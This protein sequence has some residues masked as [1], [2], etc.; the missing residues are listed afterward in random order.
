VFVAYRQLMRDLA[1]LGLSPGDM[2]MVHSSMRAIGRVL[3]GPD[4]V[5]QALLDV[6]GPVEPT[7][8]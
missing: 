2:V 7:P 6:V 3:G 4:A 8:L 5:I 1:G